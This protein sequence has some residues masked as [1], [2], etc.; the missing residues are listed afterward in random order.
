MNGWKDKP[1]P[2]GLTADPI[3]FVALL[4]GIYEHSAWVAE[5]AWATEPSTF[6]ELAAAMSVAVE[7]AGENAQLGLLRAHPEL[8]GKAALAGEL[9]H[10]SSGEQASAG[11]SHCSAE[12]LA[13]IHELNALYSDRFGFPF[14]VAVTGLTR[15]EIIEQMARR[16]NSDPASERLEALA[17]VH[18]IAEIRL[19]SLA[20][21]Y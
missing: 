11:L 18:R 21:N 8:A 6:G 10:A 12:E 3:Q 5:T 19:R 1:L 20:E 7:N 14:I 9:T 4:G 16:C 2:N 15:R 13:R 17:Q